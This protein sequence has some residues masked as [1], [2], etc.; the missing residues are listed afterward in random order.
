[1]G[2]QPVELPMTSQIA[3]G[4]GFAG[5]IRDGQTVWNEQGDDVKHVSDAES[6]AIADPDHDWR[7]VFEGPLRG[8]TYQRHAPGKWLLVK[9]S[10]GFA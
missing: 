1:M 7:I 3:V 10:E 5:I 6:M 4:F 9:Q 2:S 8:S